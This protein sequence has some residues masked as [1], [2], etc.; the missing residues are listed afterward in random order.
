[1]V[2]E[3]IIL[4]TLSRSDIDMV[5]GQ[6][7]FVSTENSMGVVE[8]SKGMLKPVSDNLINETQIVCRMAMATL[9]SRSV[10]NW[11]RFHDSYDAVRDD[12]RK[13]H[14]PALRSIMKE[15]VSKK[16]FT[17]PTPRGMNNGLRDNSIIVPRLLLLQFRTTDLLK[18]NT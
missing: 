17:C 7:Q 2:M 14:S 5:N 18:T 9:G 12:I 6:H 8:S 3:A 15:S 13:V 1:M 11:Q 4:P 16:G 10:V